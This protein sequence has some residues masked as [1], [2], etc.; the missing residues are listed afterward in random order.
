VLFATL[1]VFFVATPLVESGGY[2]QL[3][4]NLMIIWAMLMALR[5]A[6]Q[7]WRIV[8]L[9]MLLGVGAVAERVLLLVGVPLAQAVIFQVLSM[10]AFLLVVSIPI[11]LDVYRASVVDF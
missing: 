2:I 5:T 6:V 1:V 11:L 7:G 9:A 10:I 4:L 8:A 3:G